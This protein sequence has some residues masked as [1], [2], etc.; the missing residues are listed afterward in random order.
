MLE[1][2]QTDTFRP[3]SHIGQ[4]DPRQAGYVVFDEHGERPKTIDDIY[5]CVEEWTLNGSAPKDIAVAFD[6]AME[7][8]VH[9]WFNLRFIQIAQQ[10]AYATVEMALRIRLQNEWQ[11]HVATAKAAGKRIPA[12]PTFAPLLKLA[13]ELGMLCD[14]GFRQYHRIQESRNEYNEAMRFVY[15]DDSRVPAPPRSDAYVR[16]LAERMPSVRNGLAHGS[17][18]LYPAVFVHFEI[19]CDILNQLYP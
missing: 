14:N 9:S 6:T 19:C 2:V 18:T 15:G 17:S 16:L 1:E 7:L 10:H 11:N 4:P 3:L 12:R 5:R 13:I 8:L